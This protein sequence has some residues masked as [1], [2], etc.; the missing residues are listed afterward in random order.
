MDAV[1]NFA[2]STVATAPSPATTGT[3][4]TLSSGDGSL[5]PDPSTDGQFNVVIKPAGEE[6][7]T[8][9]AEIVRV[10]ARS[11]D[12][13]T[14]TRQQEGTSARTVVTGDEVYLAFTK[15]VYDD[16]AN[17]TT[18]PSG[19][20]SAISV[21]DNTGGDTISTSWT[22]VNLD[23]IKNST[24]YD[25]GNYSLA[26]DAVTVNEAG[27]YLITYEVSAYL[28]AAGTRSGLGATLEVDGGAGYSAV[29]GAARYAYGRINT[30]P[31]GTAGGSIILDLDVGDKVRLS[32]IGVTQGFVSIS[33]ASQMSIVKLEGVKGDTGDGLGDGWVL[34][35]ETWT[36]AS[37]STF[38]ISGDVSSK[39]AVGDKI[40]LTQSST[41]KYWYIVGV[42]Y[43]SPN[44]TITIAVNDDY[45]L[46]SATITDNYY[47]KIGGLPEGFPSSF[48]IS[49]AISLSGSGS[50]T[51]SGVTINAAHFHIIGDRVFYTILADFTLGGTASN[52]V[53]VS[54]IPLS[55]SSAKKRGATG[56]TNTAS[57]IGLWYSSSGA[58]NFRLY[59]SGNWTTGS[60]KS[61]FAADVSFIYA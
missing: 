35:D 40:K 38:T 47:S 53:I 9:N 27:M 14:I 37:A 22:T 12:V 31:M 48:D 3:S 23:S 24:S 33:G 59:N 56:I 25:S 39:Y 20:L 34:A 6:P 26:S 36:Y 43:S 51:V 42:S 5:F 16:I 58:L 57:E 61:I 21:F 28:G 49:S 41:T 15:K 18:F 4:L 19:D 13:L 46:T 29:T 45:T 32:A 1:E 7:T 52:T 2:K 10:T 60:G 8:S 30:E 54:G 55:D 11:G 44:T 50:M 17:A